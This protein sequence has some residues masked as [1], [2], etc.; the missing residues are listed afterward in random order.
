[1]EMVVCHEDH[2]K[3]NQFATLKRHG[4]CRQRNNPFL[5]LIF[6]LAYMFF[7]R[8][9][10]HK[11]IPNW[12]EDSETS[13][14]MEEFIFHSDRSK[15]RGMANSTA[16]R[17]LNLCYL[18][19]FPP[20][21]GYRISHLSQKSASQDAD[22]AGLPESQMK[23]QG[24]WWEEESM[25]RANF[26]MQIIRWSAHHGRDRGNYHLNR[27]VPPPP[28]LVDRV[29]PFLEHWR[30]LQARPLVSGGRKSLSCWSSSERC[31]CRTSP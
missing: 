14:W 12:E 16:N 24:C 29:F 23:R 25:F 28:G 5:C 9:V 6:H 27:E 10:V 18:R 15:F 1:M 31:C 19:I 17:L 7:L 3:A 20:I 11:N 8:F 30:Q 2:S 13:T 26:P 22:K 21:K 4:M